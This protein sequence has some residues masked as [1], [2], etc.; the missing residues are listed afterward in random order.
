MLAVIYNTVT[1]IIGSLIGLFFRKKIPSGWSPE[2]MSAI[3]LV[4]IFIGVKGG[5]D[6]NNMLIVIISIALGTLIGLAFD[7]DGKV[8]RFADRVGDK[9]K[10]KS[11][12]DNVAEGFLTACMVYC[13]GAMTIVGSLQ[14]GLDHN[15]DLLLTKGTMDGVGS[16][17]FA[18]SLGIGV[19]LSS[20]FIFTFQGALV[21]LAG[22]LAPLLSDAIVAEMSAAGSILLIGMGLNIMGVTKMKIMNSTPAI[23]LPILIVPLF[24]WITNV[25]GGIL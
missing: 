12:G 20:G 6:S 5:F 14:A 16:I 19:L 22:T 8:N 2:I 10:G 17:F 4:T 11:D 13:V 9:F 23:F 21:L 3:S 7:L 25:V 24:E 15:Y 1:V 18:A